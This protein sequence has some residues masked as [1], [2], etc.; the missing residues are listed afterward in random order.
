MALGRVNKHKMHGVDEKDVTDKVSY[1]SYLKLVDRKNK[2]L[3]PLLVHRWMLNEI[4][5]LSNTPVDQLHQN[6]NLSAFNKEE[7]GDFFK[8]MKEKKTDAAIIEE[9]KIKLIPF[10]HDLAVKNVKDGE[11]DFKFLKNN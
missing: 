8:M 4:G 6:E 2:K 3:Q 7:L 5:I 1:N 10:Y 11:V 9:I